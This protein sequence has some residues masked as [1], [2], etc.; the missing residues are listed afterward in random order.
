[1]KETLYV[2]VRW[3]D[4]SILL[5]GIMLAGVFISGPDAFL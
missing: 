4:D 1:M 2:A 5:A 3:G